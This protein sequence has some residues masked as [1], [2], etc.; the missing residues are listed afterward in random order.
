MCVQDGLQSNEESWLNGPIEEDSGWTPD[1]NGV[2]SGRNIYGA[3]TVCQTD[4]CLIFTATL[5]NLHVN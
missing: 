5:E 3:P 2:G 4:S 1:Y